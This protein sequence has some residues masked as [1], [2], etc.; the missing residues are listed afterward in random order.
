MSETSAQGRSFGVGAVV[1][2]GV[3]VGG[4]VDIAAG[5]FLA[6]G[7]G[8]GRCRGPPQ[9]RCLIYPLR[10]CRPPGPSVGSMLVANLLISGRI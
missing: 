2:A 9:V 3:G 1:D 7:A 5:A 10:V 6:L 8:V 4:G